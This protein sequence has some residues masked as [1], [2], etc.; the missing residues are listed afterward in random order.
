MDDEKNYGAEID[1]NNIGKEIIVPRLRPKNWNG[2]DYGLWAEMMPEDAPNAPIVVFGIDRKNTV[3]FPQK[4]VFKD[5]GLSQEEIMTRSIRFLHDQNPTWQEFNTHTEE[6]KLPR[7]LV[8]EHEYA[9][10]QML[11]QEFMIQACVKLNCSHVFI[12]ATCRHRIMVTPATE[13]KEDI[14]NFILL[15][16]FSFGNNPTEAITPGIFISNRDGI[17]V[18]SMVYPQ[19]LFDDVMRHIESQDDSEVLVTSY[20]TSQSKGIR[21]E[22]FGSKPSMLFEKIW[23]GYIQGGNNIRMQLIRNNVSKITVQLVLDIDK[24]PPLELFDQEIEDLKKKIDGSNKDLEAIAGNQPILLE[25][26]LRR[27]DGSTTNYD[28]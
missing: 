2:K 23:L 3:I 16:L 6:F 15:Q 27:A 13:N 9:A 21:I 4:S 8:F 14:F 24:M 28:L 25:I 19:A 26:V 5:S 7:S 1:F 18:G 10:E 12:G 11:N 20:E 22:A 17:I